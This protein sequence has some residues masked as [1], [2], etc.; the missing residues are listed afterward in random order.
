MG[1][2]Q[3][4][5]GQLIAPF[6][7]GSLYTDRFGVPHLVAGL[8]HWFKRV[9]ASGKLVECSDPSEFE[10]F[11]RRLSDLLKVDRFRKPPDHRQVLSNQEPPPNAGLTVPAVR[12]PRWYRN[13]K[14]GAMRRFNLETRALVNP[15]DGGQWHPVRFVSVCAHGHIADFPWKEWIQ[16]SCT[17][18]GNLEITDRGGSELSSITVRCSSCPDGSRGRRGRSLS[19]TTTRPRPE[20]GEKTEFEKAGIR[21]PA[22]RPW[23]G[24]GAHDAPC[25]EPLVAALIN[26]TNIYFPRTISALSIPRLDVVDDDVAVLRREIEQLPELAIV[27]TLWRMNAVEQAAAM[28]IPTL[29]KLLDKEP[30]QEA[31]QRALLSIFNQQTSAGEC[32]IAPSEPE[33]ELQSFRRTEFDVIRA[34]Y[35][36]PRESK[37]RVIQGEVAPGIGQWFCRVALVER[38]CETRVLYG[39]DRLE[40]TRDA[41]SEMPASAMQ[42][43]FREPP[44]AAS[45]RW[46]PAVEVFG[47][48]I[49][50]ELNEAALK[51]WQSSNKDWIGAR[52]G[53][54]FKQRLQDACWM[55]SPLEPVDA[56]WASRFLLVHTL[57]HILISQLV[58]ECGYSTAALRERLFVSDDPTAPMAG[59][60]IYTSAGDSEGTLGGLVRLGEP[61]L[62]G[63]IIQR[64]L[65]RASWCSADPVCSESLG[66]RGSRLANLGACH[67]CTLLPETACETINQ[68]LDRGMVVGTPEMRN[69]GFFSKLL[70]SSPSYAE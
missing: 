31:V 58:F 2:K 64:A 28:T 63:P 56:S 33:T 38:V 17:G 59:A 9:D 44:V 21:C 57:A 65:E 19:G 26:Q 23:L 18:D 10:L 37:L 24:A 48:G 15:P 66:G 7:P 12:F 22:E 20:T 16:C 55:V 13:T 45:D 3:I 69:K 61:H 4:R 11:E 51:S 34:G 52:L 47:E 41:L 49:Y 43:L 50:F 32:A 35:D 60:L 14:S 70:D 54:E 67:A 42:Q 62:F 46:L 53:G 40:P 68:G 27:K 1:S 29:K 36:D 25:D 8:D 30:T 5:L 6:G 39:F